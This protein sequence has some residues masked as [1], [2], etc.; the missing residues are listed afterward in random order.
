MAMAT[1]VMCPHCSAQNPAG[2]AFCESC[3][4]AMPRG[5]PGGPRVLAADEVPTSSA[6]TKL[7]GDELNTQTKSAANALLIVGIIQIVVGGV[8]TALLV[9]ASNRSSAVRLNLPLLLATTIGIG[10][11]FI[12]LYFWARRSPLPATVVGLVI[13]GTLVAI[14]VVSAISNMSERGPGGNGIGGLGIGWLDIVII[15]ILARGIGAALR[16]RR[17]LAAQTV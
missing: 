3:G 8:V 7:V 13:Y 12:G 11:I 5:M 15:A 17:L 6:A 2:V 10:L 14:N 4:K 9:A 16:Q 1:M